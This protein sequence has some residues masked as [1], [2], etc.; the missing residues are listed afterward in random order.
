MPYTPDLLF[1]GALKTTLT[2]VLA[3]AG[4]AE[5]LLVKHVTFCNTTTVDVSVT[6]VLGPAHV[7]SGMTIPAKST[8]E[9]PMSQIVVAGATITGGA[10]AAGVDCLISGVRIT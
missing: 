2:T 3:T 5:K 9:I 4:A 6:L 10:S 8:I 1:G 7:A